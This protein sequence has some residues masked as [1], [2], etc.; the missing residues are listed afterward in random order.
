[1]LLSLAGTTITNGIFSEKT[2]TEAYVVNKMV[3][4]V[5]GCG[6]AINHKS[7]LLVPEDYRSMLILD[8]I[9]VN[10]D[11]VIENNQVCEN[12]L[13]QASFSL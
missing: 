7:E 8:D 13:L 5:K 1:M 3:I 6:I 4:A 2:E 11:L 9:S 12:L 10:M